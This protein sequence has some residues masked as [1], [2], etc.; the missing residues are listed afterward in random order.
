MSGK[1]LTYKLVI[2]MAMTSASRASIMHCLNVRF[3]VKS[4]DLYTLTFHWLNQR[5]ST[6]SLFISCKKV[7]E[8]VKHH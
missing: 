5:I 3:M 8:R 4:E 7:G 1:Y 6:L 2:L